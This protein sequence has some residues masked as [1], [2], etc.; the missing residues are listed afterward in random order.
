[1][2]LWRWLSSKWIF[3]FIYFFYFGQVLK[4]FLNGG[5]CVFYVQAHRK[6]AHRTADQ[7][8]PQRDN[9]AEGPGERHLKGG[10]GTVKFT[11]G[12]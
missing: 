4:L 10:E 1:M 3:L 6:G 2:Q 8:A 12:A 9:D 7:D 11:F 5:L